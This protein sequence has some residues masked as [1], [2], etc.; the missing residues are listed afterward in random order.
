MAQVYTKH[1]FDDLNFS[2]IILNFSRK[3]NK[4]WLPFGHFE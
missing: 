1:L 2:L 4:K 3:G